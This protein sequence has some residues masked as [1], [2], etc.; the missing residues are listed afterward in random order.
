[1]TDLRKYGPW[2]LIAGGSEG[3]GAEFARKLAIAGINLVLVARMEGPLQTL[4]AELTSTGV[5]I[6]TATL[7]LAKPDMLPA[8]RQLTDD[9]DIGLLIYN[10]GTDNRAADFL[11]VPI[12]RV[13][14][15]IHLSI[16]GQ[17]LLCHHFGTRMRARGGGGIILVGS[18]LGYA[19]GGAMSVYA[20]AKAYSHTLA[21][22]LWHE[23]RPAGVDVLGL[24]VSATATPAYER[25]GLAASHGAII[26]SRPEDVAQEGLEMLPHGPL[27]IVRAAQAFAAH[28]QSLPVQE[29]VELVTASAAAMRG[30]T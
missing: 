8:I 11:D 15:S 26:A 6:R 27:H 5:Q 10:A 18:L 4:A 25:M 17:T 21:K 13:Q 19:G 28:L 16:T 24:V 3:I 2:A 22:G 20:A 29:A 30:E 1:M 12:D 23:L 14:Y 7:N 9:L